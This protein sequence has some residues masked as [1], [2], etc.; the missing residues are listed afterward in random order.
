MRISWFYSK[1]FTT[2]IN[3]SYSMKSGGETLESESKDSG[4][5]SNPLSFIRGGFYSYMGASLYAR[6]VRGAYW[7]LQSGSESNS[8]TSRDL[9]F[10]SANLLTQ[11]YNDRGDGFAVRCV[12][13]LQIL[14]HSH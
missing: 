13:V 9:Y 12:A 1:S 3:T 7:S 2:L 11:D 10:H 4:L 14:H 5:L 6:S 8:S